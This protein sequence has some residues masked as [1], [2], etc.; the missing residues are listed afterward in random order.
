MARDISDVL[1]FR[2]DLSPFLVHLTK[3]TS[4]SARK[5]LISIL[6][7]KEL[8]Y[9]TKLMSPAWYRYPRFNKLN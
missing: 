5:N 7:S 4:S 9:G 1:R 6:E 2:S 3:D 8:R